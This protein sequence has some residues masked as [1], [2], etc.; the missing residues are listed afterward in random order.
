MPN[1]TVTGVLVTPRVAGSKRSWCSASP[2]V[3]YL[4]LSTPSLSTSTPPA[5]STDPSRVRV[6]VW[7]ATGGGR[8]TAGT[9]TR[10]SG[11]LGRTSSPAVP[12]TSGAPTLPPQTKK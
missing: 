10:L 9:S 6:A 11:S 5:T 1:G 2:P 7:N 4:K 3:G 12:S 8:P